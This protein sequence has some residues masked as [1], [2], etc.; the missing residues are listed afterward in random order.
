MK[1]F[2]MILA[3]SRLTTLIPRNAHS[4]SLHLSKFSKEFKKTVWKNNI[5]SISFVQHRINRVTAAKI[6]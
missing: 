4:N 3:Y 6:K 2:S 1:Y 5:Q